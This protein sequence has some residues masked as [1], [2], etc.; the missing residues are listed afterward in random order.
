MVDAAATKSSRTSGAPPQNLT[1]REL[2]FSRTE[3]WPDNVTGPLDND[4]W[5]RRLGASLWKASDPGID[6]WSYLTL[7]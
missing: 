6:H 1:G 2:V 7:F 5:P 3:Y 4:E